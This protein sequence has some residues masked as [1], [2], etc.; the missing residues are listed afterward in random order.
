TQPGKGSVT[1]N[2]DNTITYT[3]Q[4]NYSG[5]DSFS[6]IVS[7]GAGGSASA[8][9]LVTVTPSNDAPVAQDGVVNVNE[10]SSVNTSMV[11]TDVD[12]ASLNYSVVTPPSHG[13]LVI[14]N[15]NTGAYTYTP[16]PNYNGTDSFTFKVNDGEVDSNVATV[17]ITVNSINDAPVANNNLV[18]VA[19]DS[20]ASIVLEATDADANT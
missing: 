8:M 3:P 6:Y 4:S 11:A 12:S 7:D 2:G 19:E 9:V 1:I 14:T 20:S 5:S 18:N 10:D 13:T 15:I 16:E 17:N